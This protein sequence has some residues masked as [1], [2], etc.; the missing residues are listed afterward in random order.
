MLVISLGLN[1][2][3]VILKHRSVLAGH[4]FPKYALYLFSMVLGHFSQGMAVSVPL[5][6]AWQF[7][8]CM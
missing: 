5:A 1:S 4:F 6:T 8:I 7:K 2:A 3:L